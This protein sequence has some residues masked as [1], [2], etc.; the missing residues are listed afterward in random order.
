MFK[1]LLSH[2]LLNE[3][4]KL[5]YRFLFGLESFS[6]NGTTVNKKPHF[7]QIIDK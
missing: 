6:A 3:Q 2:H 4:H 7:F 1:I 5:A